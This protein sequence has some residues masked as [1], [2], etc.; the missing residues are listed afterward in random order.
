MA[1]KK[2]KNATGGEKIYIPIKEEPWASTICV[3]FREPDSIMTPTRLS[4]MEIS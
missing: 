4:P 1:I 3:K 2:T